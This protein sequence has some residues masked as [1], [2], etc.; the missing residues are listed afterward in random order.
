MV[1]SV[2]STRKVTSRQALIANLSVDQ[3]FAF[4]TVARAG[5]VRAAANDLALSQPAVSQ[6]MRHL[7]SVLGIALFD[8]H[9]GQPASLTAVGEDLLEVAERILTEVDSFH[10]RLEQGKRPARSFTIVSGADHIKYLLLTAVAALKRRH[11]GI[12]VV[13]KHEATAHDTTEALLAGR[14]DVGFC[15]SPA[16]EGLRRLGI[17]SEELFLVAH[18][19]HKVVKMGPSE[20]LHA[21]STTDL[22]TYAPG[23]R[24][25]QLV[26]RWAQKHD[27]ELNIVIE[28]RN[29]EAMRL[30][31]LENLAV[32]VLP[33]VSVTSEIAAGRLVKVPVPG[34][35]LSKETEILAPPN[36]EVP[37]EVREFLNMLPK[38]LWRAI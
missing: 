26:E 31:V 11:P 10:L 30:S 28:S 18:P 8:R 37:T 16:P 35:P 17:V 20:A 15:R 33:L 34:L 23:M 36:Q 14:A 38:G 2:P 7:E 24:S 25:R 3:L 19:E 5:T 29:V 32:A 27:V 12:R 22:A 1:A 4:Q 21:L 9:P 13:L 6:R